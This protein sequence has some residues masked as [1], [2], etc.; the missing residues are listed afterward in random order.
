[1]TGTQFVTAVHDRIGNQASGYIGTRDADTAILDSVNF[2]VKEIAKLYSSENLRRD[3]TVAVTT[4]GYKY[5]IPV[6]DTS[7]N[8][9][10]I[11][12]FIHMVNV[13]SGETTGFSIQKLTTRMRD[14]LF[15]YTSSS[16]RTGRPEFY[17]RSG[18]YIEFYPY[19]DG[20]YTV[21]GRVSIWP[22][23]L[24]ASSNSPLEDCWDYVIIAL[25]TY[26]TFSKIQQT[27]D[28]ELWRRRG[29]EEL[30]RMAYSLDS[31]PDLYMTSAVLG[32]T[33]TS[34]SDPLTDPMNRTYNV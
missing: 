20:T 14:T 33:P 19:P 21:Y 16:A 31:E 27:Q 34:S 22:E 8:T 5:A 29:Y 13:K 12:D 26:D 6:V 1:M 9:I 25:A 18:S 4:A 2:A 32:Q 28:A 11:K 17:N 30:R 24:T 15:P 7:G 10:T 23:V 3:I